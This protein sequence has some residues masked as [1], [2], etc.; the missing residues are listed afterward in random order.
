MKKYI[1]VD[2]GSENL[3]FLLISKNDEE[4][5][6]NILAKSS[7]PSAGI[8][9]GYISNQKEFKKAFCQAWQKFNTENRLENKNIF[10]S[11]NNFG[12]S[13]VK[14]SANTQ[15]ASG[16]ISEYDLEKNK[17][18][19]LHIFKKQN[20]DKLVESDFIKYNIN[21]FEYYAE[22]LGMETRKMEAEY[23][24]L[25]QNKNYFNLL[26]EIL[27]NDFNLYPVFLPGL[28][29]AGKIYLPEINRKLG[30]VLVDIGADITSLIIYENNKAIHFK[31]FKF[32]GKDISKKI[33][34]LEKIDFIEAEKI[35]KSQLNN[36]KI[37]KII[38]SELQ[39][40]AKKIASEIKKVEK[41][42]ILPGGITLVGGSSR[43]KNI[44]SIF[45]AEINLP[46]R[47][48]NKILTD[49]N[50]DYH[51]TYAILINGLKN[52]RKNSKINF[53]FFKN[54]IKL[55]TKIFKKIIP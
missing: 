29:S 16:V 34:Q 28:F 54:I 55:F 22:P 39:E 18:K 20:S 49:N 14:I 45:K 35:K 7:Y 9:F 15:V 27:N 46:I 6:F 50:T 31:I 47:R 48:A 40:L 38:E 42:N 21:N 11:W 13:G 37:S 41:E 44:E 25:T 43:F 53:L 30:S 24:F 4:S 52:E 10:V 12:M 51:L 19:A 26:D 17:N 36:K 33:A 5:S 1:A 2:L 23:F 8:S 32:G 3:K